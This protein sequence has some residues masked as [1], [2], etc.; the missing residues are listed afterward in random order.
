MAAAAP[1]LILGSAAIKG[2]GQLKQAAAMRKA[3]NFNA[4]VAE[5]NAQFSLQESAANE[6]SFRVMARKQLGD[7]RAN[8]GASG[9]VASESSAQD[10]LEESA[11]TA[12]MDALR[13]R[14]QGE[15]K[16][17]GYRQDAKL[18]RMSAAN[19]MPQG[20]LSAS[21]TL[22]DGL[23]TGYEKGYF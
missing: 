7:M 15:L 12:E 20:L 13:I 22:L 2:I 19:A 16:A 5:Q 17:Y 9:I 14:H 8:Y 4:D 3:A 18:N 1:F 6:R 23:G 11:A 21:G 10:I